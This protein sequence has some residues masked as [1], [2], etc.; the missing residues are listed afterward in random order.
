MKLQS[1]VIPFPMKMKD[2]KKYAELVDVLDTL[3]KWINQLFS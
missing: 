3:E 2:K 1:V